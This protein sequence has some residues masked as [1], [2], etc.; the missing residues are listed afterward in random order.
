MFLQPTSESEGASRLYESDMKQHGF[1]MNL[2]RLWAWRPDIFEAFAALRAQLTSQSSLSSRE[3]A[4]TLCAAVSSLGDS[5]CALAWG[6]KLASLAGPSIAGAVL[7]ASSSD[8]MT[9]RERALTTWARK[10][11]NNPNETCPADVD[12]LRIAGLSEKEI[13]EATVFIAFRLAFST[14]NDALGAEPDWQLAAVAPPEVAS[15]VAFGR[16]AASQKE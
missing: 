7:S 4:V 5:Y 14:I 2:S 3:L 15:A 9:A 16:R 1:I 6:N 10:V 13:F 8:A 11:V 12:E